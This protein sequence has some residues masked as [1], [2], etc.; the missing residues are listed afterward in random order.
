MYV[1][2][3]VCMYC[4]YAVHIWSAHTLLLQNAGMYA[5]DTEACSLISRGRHDNSKIIGIPWQ[6]GIMSD[7]VVDII[8]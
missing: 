3:M 7:I 4:I 2:A 8:L 5:C 1:Y 6:K